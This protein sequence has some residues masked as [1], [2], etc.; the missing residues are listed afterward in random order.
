MNIKYLTS[1]LSLS[2]RCRVGL[3]LYIIFELRNLPWYV[4][5]NSTKL[6]CTFHGDANAAL[7][8]Y[9]LHVATLSINCCVQKPAQGQQ[10]Q[11][12]SNICASR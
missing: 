3:V 1:L 9:L 4:T 2:L 8:P 10:H 11:R 7:V 6:V 12:Y 5:F